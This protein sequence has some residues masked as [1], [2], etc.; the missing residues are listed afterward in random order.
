M[1]GDL[2]KFGAQDGSGWYYR[3][4]QEA[5]SDPSYAENN[6]FPRLLPAPVARMR[7]VIAK[8]AA[9]SEEEKQERRDALIRKIDRVLSV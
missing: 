3:Y 7:E 8:Y 5:L 9:T 4:E 2:L 6:W 1:S